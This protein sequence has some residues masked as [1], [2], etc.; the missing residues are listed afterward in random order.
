MLELIVKLLED[1]GSLW[2][3]RDAFI[4]LS[5][6]YPVVAGVIV[7]LLLIILAYLVATNVANLAVQI[8]LWLQRPGSALGI[9]LGLIF[10]GVMSTGVVLSIRTATAPVPIFSVDK[11]TFIGEPLLLKW[12]YDKKS[13]NS[14]NNTVF[15]EI[16]SA[17][18]HNFQIDAH[19]ET[20]Y[21]DGDYK[22][23][24]HINAS[25][26]WRVRAV[27]SQVGQP[28]SDWSN[29]AQF[30]QYDSAYKRI[31]TTGTVLIYVSSAEN[32]DPFK[33]VD[34]TFKG[35][36]I[37]L[38]EGVVASLS[39]RIRIGSRPLIAKFVPIP[40]PELLN[41]PGRGQADMIISSIS[42]LRARE[43]QYK[44]VFS[45]AYFC[46]TQA[47]IF[48]AGNKDRSIDD[49][50]RGK[51]VGFQEG[52]TGERLA[53]ALKKDIPFE[54]KPSARA[55]QVI[56][57]LLHSD[58]DIGITDEP[59]ATVNRAT[60]VSGNGKPRLDVKP[61]ARKDFPSSIP[62]DEQFDEYAIAVYSSEDSLLTA[63]NE[64]ITQMKTSGNLY[65]MLEAAISE[66]EKAKN[67][68]KGSYR[69]ESER[70][71]ECPSH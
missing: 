43:E 36:D 21:V 70:P 47:M 24:Q 69:L 25:R 53:M 63:I 51:K 13:V 6:T 41:M 35:F 62:N 14:Y 66:Y 42:K 49:M 59:F 16:Q 4:A 40:W 56:Y 58:L 7:F 54:A 8:Y 1:I 52:T 19:P 38:A 50:I 31:E 67:L 60:Y 10:A 61:F 34:K 55:E 15:F 27:D 45:D 32:E 44:L 65:R 28:I 2:K 37:K 39:K 71:W 23:V 22:Y 64:A 68:A 17:A 18:D 11:D 12:K 46:T 9:I 33:W 30:T 3:L 57:A 20:G 5:Q 48:P 29:I 26:Y